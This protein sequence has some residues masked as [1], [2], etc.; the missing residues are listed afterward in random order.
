MKRIFNLLLAVIF[1]VAF[2][3]TIFPSVQN[4]VEPITVSAEDPKDSNADN[5]GL[6][7]ES[8]YF[9]EGAALWKGGDSIRW[10]SFQ[11]RLKNVNYRHYIDGEKDSMV[12]TF[13][14]N[15]VNS[16]TEQEPVPI[17]EIG[18]ASIG[19]SS[20][21]LTFYMH[22][23]LAY[24]SGVDIKDES[25]VK[26]LQKDLA[27]SSCDK[28][29][30]S[31][32]T[33][34]EEKNLFLDYSR[35]FEASGGYILD[36]ITMYKDV[37]KAEHIRFIDD[38]VPYIRINVK[39][40]SPGA[41]YFVDCKYKYDNYSHT[42]VTNLN[43]FGGR[44]PWS[45]DKIHYSHQ[46]L[47]QIRTSTRSIYGVLNNMH[48]AGGDS[49][50]QSELG[51]FYEEGNAILKNYSKE[52][53]TVS[54]LQQIG[55]L[56][57]CRKIVKTVKVPVLSVGDDKKVYHDDLCDA[58][59]L[60]TLTV[61]GSAWSGTVRE[62]SEGKYVV[63]CKYFESVYLVA[64]T[65][66]GN[67]T[68]PGSA[69]SETFYLDLNKSFEEYYGDLVN[70][71][72]LTSSA[73]EYF[74]NSLLCQDGLRAEN[75]KLVGGLQPEELYGY[76]GYVAIPQTYSFNT[77][78]GEIFDNEASLVGLYGSFNSYLTLSKSA[79][80]ELMQSYTYTWYERTWANI[81]NFIAGDPV[82]ATA[83]FFCTTAEDRRV[84]I[85]GNGVTDLDD[86]RGLAEV[87]VTEA[88][89]ELLSGLPTLLDEAQAKFE[90]TMKILLAVV[91]GVAIIAGG[92]FLYIT[93]KKK[94]Q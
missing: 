76:W 72:V 43:I 57:F 61:L 18:I 50:V 32:S 20:G 93:L 68:N 56:P 25:C 2:A 16:E 12:T 79:Y 82:D 64:R 44:T 77:L 21:V 58:L 87:Q 46:A 81:A 90:K 74:F 34:V 70:K 66:D 5:I 54:Y 42:V 39:T 36:Y 40:N 15:R 94:Q 14:L 31:T 35:S 4:I 52:E 83:Y 85:M 53:V 30:D 67:T 62:S 71:G 84:G 49:L 59:G 19:S 7:N 11:F 41:E 89:E 48:K 8:Y 51:K 6:S 27:E 80:D 91:G 33:S 10:L 88:A 1:S 24:D 47:A 13:I 55:D 45:E 78:W 26:L 69:V 23:P 63:D 22:K 9:E 75:E 28:I 37:K 86:D 3:L 65:V 29:I 38:T 17:Y 92:I 60:K 73:K